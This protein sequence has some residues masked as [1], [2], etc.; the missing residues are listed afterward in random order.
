MVDVATMDSKSLF[1]K[2]RPPLNNK[3]FQ[4]RCCVTNTKLTA[5][6]TSKVHGNVHGGWESKPPRALAT[7]KHGPGGNR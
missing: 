4:S 3:V 2:F 6:P 7:F 5:S 1:S